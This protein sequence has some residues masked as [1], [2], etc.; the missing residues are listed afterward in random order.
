MNGIVLVRIACSVAF[1]SR[2]DAHEM[3]LGARCVG[4]G[5]HL[6]WVGWPR[7]DP[8]SCPRG[9]D[10]IPDPRE[11]RTYICRVS[12]IRRVRGGARVEPERRRR[13]GRRAGP[14]VEVD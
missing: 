2:I 8:V 10:S 6:S 7:F 3:H 4:M 1:S 5:H 14:Q 12:W 9:L 13:S 11:D